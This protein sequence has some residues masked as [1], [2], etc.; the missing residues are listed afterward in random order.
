M[1]CPVCLEDVN[2][3]SS[4]H[5]TTGCGHIFHI[6]CISQIEGPCPVCRYPWMRC[7]LLIDTILV[8][9]Y[10]FLRFHHETLRESQ[11]CCS[12]CF[13]QGNNSSELALATSS[14]ITADDDTDLWVCLVCGFTGC[15]QYHQ[16]HIKEHYEESL[17]TY[18]MNVG[19]RRVWDFSGEGFVHRLIL[20]SPQNDN[21]EGSASANGSGNPKLVETS[22]LI[23]SDFRKQNIPL[24][25]SQEEA[26]INTKL[27]STFLA[28]N[29]VL[30]RCMEQT[31]IV[32]E[33]RLKRIRESS[34]LDS[35]ETS[36][37]NSKSWVESLMTSLSGERNKLLR[38]LKAAKERL[39]RSQKELDILLELN[40][41]L[42][43][44]LAQWESRV[45]EAELRVEETKKTARS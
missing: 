25:S 5:F 16:S 1:F 38:Q 12:V 19:S 29:E 34:Q 39:Q 20:N 40:V 26:L 27:E 13:W 15:G 32:Y 21:E 6:D 28:Y 30:A 31:R 41:N 4:Q 37:S 23:S 44:N 8:I 3:S 7:Y 45:K 11:S 9:K 22:N 24:S 10:C 35:Q 43:S 18:A 33:A 36:S 42:K 17:H 2:T 14:E